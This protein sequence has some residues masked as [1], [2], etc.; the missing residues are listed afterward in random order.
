MYLKKSKHKNGRVHISVAEGYYDKTTGKTKTVNVKTLGYLDILEK[1]YQDPISHFSEEVRR[2]NE[3][4]SS[5]KAPVTFNVSLNEK[6]ISGMDTR[7]SFGYAALSKI[8]HELKI[9]TFLINRQRHSKED[10]DANAIMKLLIFSRLLY[11][12]SKKKTFEN[13]GVFFEKA[14]FSLDDVYR[15]LSFL[16]KHKA[17]LLLWLHKHIQKQYNRDTSLVFYDVTNYYFE[18]DEQD[19][20][21]RKGVSKEHRPD[22][23]IQMGLFMDNNGIPITYSL[24]PG[25][26][27]DKQTL[28]P[29]L[30]KIL[31]DFSLGRIIIVADRG[32][33]TGDNIYYTLSAKN[34]YV[35]S[36]SIRSADAAFKKYVLDQ[37]GYAEKDDGFKIKSR[38]YPREISITMK[39]GRKKKVTVDEKQLIFYSKKYAEKA[40]ADRA[41]V[42]EKAKD[43]IKNPHQ[44]TRATSQGAAKYIK[45]LSFDA[46]TGEILESAKKALFF[47]E[48]K[49]RQE[50]KFDGYY[51]IV[52]SEYREPD[53]RII[54][55]YRGLWKIEESFKITKSDLESRPVYL[56]T[57]EHIEAHFL[58][59]FLSLVLVRILEYRLKRKYSATAMLEG[60]G[61][62]SCSHIQENYYLF[63]YYDDILADIGTELGI[64]FSKKYMSL[65]EIKKILG[66]V[67]K[68]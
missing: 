43:L 63:N 52:T 29:M 7:K 18:I 56:S 24:Y 20:L 64:D 14:D 33:T 30:R 65:G 42:L 19:E 21:R 50:E 66:A 12:S 41:W 31:H 27:L 23:I 45:N 9:H 53:E 38:L 32:M 1:Q 48:E 28:I 11:P 62:A 8:Y 46:K 34:G 15:C 4:K 51:A 37:D 54:E 55:I 40:K 67:K 22:P 25:N 16:N 3:L 5:E 61:K 47:D 39:S 17:E 60:L 44:Y 13:R 6:L 68:S 57:K 26:M 59:C 10:Y 36:Y 2:M 35:L 49:L 58:T